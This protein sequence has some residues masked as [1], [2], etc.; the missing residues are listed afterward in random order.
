MLYA[1]KPISPNYLLHHGLN[2]NFIINVLSPTYHGPISTSSSLIV[3]Q[4]FSQSRGQIWTLKSSFANLYKLI[5]GLP[6]DWISQFKN[7]NETLL[8][9]SALPIANTKNFAD[10][11]GLKVTIILK[12]LL[13]M[14]N[15]IS[16]QHF[17]QTIGFKIE[18]EWLPIIANH[19]LLYKEN[20]YL[21]TLFYIDY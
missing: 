1:C 14:K 11:V 2:Q 18:N 16:N 9:N 20:K 8:F 5:V 19:E 17:Y 21:K 10:T 13:F 7:E 4:Q 6:V 3:A 12:Q 15:T